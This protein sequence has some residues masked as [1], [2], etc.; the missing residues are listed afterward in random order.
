MSQN[1]DMGFKPVSA[2]EGISFPLENL[3]LVPLQEL[4]IDG[5]LKQRGVAGD[6]R[7]P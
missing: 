3:F 7:Q 5:I 2:L 1:R 4:R 6:N